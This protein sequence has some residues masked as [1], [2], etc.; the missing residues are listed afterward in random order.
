[1]IF[2]LYA[3]YSKKRNETAKFVQI[4]HHAGEVENHM[5]VITWDRIGK[6]TNYSP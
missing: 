6:F 4:L 5:I 1:M 2:V 3:I